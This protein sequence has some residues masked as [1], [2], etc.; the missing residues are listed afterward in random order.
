M[1]IDYERLCAHIR[2]RVPVVRRLLRH[3]ALL[4]RRAAAR[5]AH[6]L[7]L[8]EGRGD[9]AAAPLRGGQSRLR[10]RRRR[11]CE[12]HV[13]Q[14]TR[15]GVSAS[16]HVLIVAV[17]LAAPHRLS[18]ASLLRY[19]NMKHVVLCCSAVEALPLGV[20]NARQCARPAHDAPPVCIIHIL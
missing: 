3:A 6:H 20:W 10:R 9:A 17:K 14:T 16:C 19:H 5:A 8:R 12:P 11:H 15:A 18:S 4:E 13:A 1:I 7:P 2:C